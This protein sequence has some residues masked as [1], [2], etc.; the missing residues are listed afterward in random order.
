MEKNLNDLFGQPNTLVLLFDSNIFLLFASSEIAQD[1]F[2][3]SQT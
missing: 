2:L 1:K 3:T